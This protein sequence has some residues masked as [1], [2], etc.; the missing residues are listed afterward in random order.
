MSKY[1]AFISYTHH[2]EMPLATALDNALTRFAKPWNRL[3]ALRI[4]RDT[5]SQ[6]LTPNLLGA[7]EKAMDESEFL[8]L[9]AS[10]SSSASHWVPREVD[11]WV[12]NNPLENLLI[13]VC[14]GEIVWDD[15]AGDFDWDKTDC[16]P[17]T[18]KGVYEGSPLY[19]DMRWSKGEEKLD[20]HHHQFKDNIA[21][22]SA[23]VNGKSK[24][25]ML[26]EEVTQFRRTT[27]IR[28]AAITTLSMLLVATAVA[29][30]LAVQAR[31][32]AERQRDKA[33]KTSLRILVQ[34]E[35]DNNRLGHA[36]QIASAAR[37][38]FGDDPLVREMGWQL[39]SHPTA[40]VN[41]FRGV[42]TQFHRFSPDG[43]RL[44]T[45]LTNQGGSLDILV[46]DRLGGNEHLLQDVYAAHFIGDGSRLLLLKPSALM[47]LMV[48]GVTPG[49][50]DVVSG[51]ENWVDWNPVNQAG[52]PQYS[53]SLTN[54]V[55][56]PW[57]YDLETRETNHWEGEWF[58]G[59]D[60]TCGDFVRLFDDDG[61]HQ[62]NV[63]A[64]GANGAVVSANGQR[65]AVVTDDGIL[66]MD[67][68]GTVSATL[69]GENPVLSS[70]GSLIATV[71]LEVDG[72]DYD[73]DT[74]VPFCI[75]LFTGIEYEGPW[76]E[77]A[78]EVVQEKIC[79]PQ[80]LDIA[81]RGFTQVFT[82]SGEQ[83]ALLPG[84][85][86]VFAWDGIVTLGGQ[87]VDG[88]PDQQPRLWDLQADA[89]GEHPMLLQMQ[90]FKVVVSP[91][92]KWIASGSRFNEKTW[93]WHRSGRFHAMV[94]GGDPVW[95]P[96]Q[97]MLLTNLWG[98]VRIWHIERLKSGSRE[99]VANIIEVP[100]E[101]MDAEDDFDFWAEC[102]AECDPGPRYQV[103]LEGIKTPVISVTPGTSVE[104]VELET[105]IRITRSPLA[106]P[107]TEADGQFTM[108]QHKVLGCDA[109]STR[110]KGNLMLLACRAD[111]TWRIYDLDADKSYIDPQNHHAI[112]IGKHGPNLQQAG[113]SPDG[114]QII[115]IDVDGL[116]RLWDISSGTTTSTPIELDLGEKALMYAFSPDSEM[117]AL[118][119]FS[120]V[121]RLW[122][123]AGE[124]LAAMPL[125]DSREHFR[126][127]RFF[128][129]GKHLVFAGTDKNEVNFYTIWTTD[130]DALY[131][132]FSWLPKLTPDPLTQ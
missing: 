26:S 102:D 6:A 41:D 67:D 32:E 121:A 106:E 85:H 86:P 24:E 105:V 108:V 77:P 14:D 81:G 125:R 112:L 73:P 101:A 114:N 123:T 30:M 43:T 3:R 5:D 66:V 94:E 100:K 20:L 88:E 15:E 19:L 47:Q 60:Q 80:E 44:M 34:N 25:D 78:P 107:V 22:L 27:R 95:V 37:E 116:A 28:N 50:D 75:H 49:G 54:G 69:P 57:V 2:S 12:K 46:Q 90:G 104:P 87:E 64:P 35:L 83:V 111:G 13:V 45:G 55:A 99:V 52:G 33:I 109:Q 61:G 65:I 11:H 79:E 18:L 92:G 63:W 131:D 93:I 110:Y 103:N 130:L 40:V 115:S 23:T 127:M 72:E 62:R 38:R 39:V 58:S 84:T 97:P 124:L 10:P 119:P 36:V 51:C 1:N 71:T 9:L 76:G 4:Y 31:N 89:E 17:E 59:Q 118:T 29:A 122:N 113:F 129:E 56:S 98:R 128:N 74:D 96:G 7:V 8:I 42:A 70:D 120:G 82:T 48:S 21:R 91:D 16:L 53:Y 126:G 117:V 132:E 68:G